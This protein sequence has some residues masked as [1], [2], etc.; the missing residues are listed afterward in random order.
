MKVLVTGSRYYSDYSIM[1][2]ELEALPKDTVLIHGG[3]VGADA[4]ADLIGR[5]LG[6]K[7]MVFNADWAK[8]GKAAGPIRNSEMLKEKPDLVLAFP[9]EGSKGTWDTVSKARGLGIEVKVI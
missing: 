4:L 3:C 2:K 8:N 7:I 6:F 5:Q 9:L 1:K